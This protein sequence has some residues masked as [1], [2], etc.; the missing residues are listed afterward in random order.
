[1]ITRRRFFSLLVASSLFWMDR[2]GIVLA[3]PPRRSTD[4]PLVLGRP[5]M[6]TIVEIQAVHPE[7]ELARAGMKAALDRMANV[8]T[9]MSAQRSRSEINR[10]SRFAAMGPVT[11]EAETY[12]VLTEAMALAAR[13][14]GAIDV[15]IRPLTAVWERATAR[16]CLPSPHELDAVLP[17]VDSRNVQLGPAPLTVSFAQA[18]M[19]L[20]FGGIAKGYAADVGAETLVRRGIGQGVIDAGGDLRVLGRGPDGR[21]WRIALRHP[22][23]PRRLL[24]TVLAEDESIA[25]SGNYFTPFRIQG[26]AYGHLLHPRNGYSTSTLL[27]ATVLTQSAIRADG[28]ATAAVVLGLDGAL[29]VLDRE[30]GME[31]ILVTRSLTRP[32]RL[33]IHITRGL[34]SRIGLLS[35]DADLVG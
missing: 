30:P 20:D 21:P 1:M 10:I 25:T 24:L 18:G 17:L 28:L 14:A 8:D 11:V 29:A 35:K 3:R 31:G 15:T 27:S 22:V 34:H 4:R 23:H 6:G 16:G 12:R 13:T 33:E 9:L 26:Q 32:G 2:E 19:A 5:M 7:P